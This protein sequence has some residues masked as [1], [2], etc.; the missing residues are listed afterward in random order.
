MKIGDKII[1]P[2]FGV[3]TIIVI[4][5]VKC[6]LDI[7]VEFEKER[8]NLHSGNGLGRQNHCYWISSESCVYYNSIRE[9]LLKECEV[10][11]CEDFLY[12]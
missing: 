9:Q 4:D 2:T 8:E 1:H 11:L 10:K 6:D 7:L 12:F 5:N 3:G